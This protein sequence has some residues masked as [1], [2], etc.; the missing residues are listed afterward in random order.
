MRGTFKFNSNY[1]T[2]TFF[3]LPWAGYHK[4]VFKRL[5]NK[6]LAQITGPKE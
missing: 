2:E 5:E 6:T 4:A 3:A 1:N